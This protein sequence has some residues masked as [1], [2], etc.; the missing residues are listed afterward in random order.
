MYSREFVCGMNDILAS[1]GVFLPCSR[2]IS[3][4]MFGLSQNGGHPSSFFPSATPLFISLLPSFL[5]TFLLLAIAPPSLLQHHVCA[6]CERPFHGHPY[7]ER[8]DHA[9]CEKHFN[10]VRG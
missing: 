8:G 3:V 4:V 1:S 10:M 5:S 7:Y 9:Y 2:I 6:L